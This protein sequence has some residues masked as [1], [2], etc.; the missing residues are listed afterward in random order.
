MGSGEKRL[1]EALVVLGMHRSGTSSVAG[2]L[3]LLG[4]TAPLTLM[5]DHPDNSR[6]YWE[7]Q[8]LT[9]LSDEI[10]ESGG[11]SWSDWRP[12]SRTWARSRAG[13]ALSSAMVAS[14]ES[15][16]KGAPLIVLKDPRM[17]RLFPIWNAALKAA[18]YEPR[19][20]TPLRSPIEVAASLTARDGFSQARGFLIWLRNVL[21]AEA[22][23][24]GLRR[25]FFRWTDF[26]GDW[27]KELD[28]ATD[29]LG[30]ILPGRSDFG[31]K[32]VDAFLDGKLRRQVANV[33]LP[34]HAPEWLLRAHDALNRLLGDPND[35][36]AEREL[37]DIRVDFDSTSRLLGPAF[38]E[39]EAEQSAR[40]AAQA[41]QIE[42][43][44]ADLA[45]ACGE[46]DYLAVE[47]NRIE[48][49]LA[50]TRAELAGAQTRV[51][52]LATKADG[53]QAA[54]TDALARN[55]S[56]AGQYKETCGHRDRLEA[57]RDEIRNALH[58]AA[59]QVA[60]GNASVEMLSRRLS[61]PNPELQQP[62]RWPGGVP[63]AH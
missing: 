36:S 29:A 61:E 10:L 18:G 62:S 16:F 15:E 6:G 9:R 21:E 34:S 51:E 39:I 55:E 11:S 47:R 52:D 19:I 31:D 58:A 7:S 27:R 25:H 43:L 28:R 42:L 38:V 41:R 48:G 45:A 14:L 24:R 23:S 3:A 46:R 17:C 63:P 2:T 50:A 44:T 56:L 22:A 57:E 33:G 53:L 32:R 35:A 60:Q 4:A 49:A 26:L 59:T 54:L 37:N 40:N 13:K 12:F 8:I 20:M 1:S 30:V 5:P